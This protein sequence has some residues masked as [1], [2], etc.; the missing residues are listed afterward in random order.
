MSVTNY[1]YG[2]NS[3][4]VNIVNELNSTNIM[5]GVDTA[6][7]TLGWTKIREL[8]NAVPGSFTSTSTFSPMKTYVYKALNADTTTYKYL[9]IDWD[10][11][12]LMFFTSTCES[13]DE[14]S[15]IATNQSWAGAGA[16]AQRYDLKDCFIFVGASTRHIVLWS[17]PK[18][19]P[20]IWTGVFEFERTVPEDTVANAAPCWA[21]T[22]S[23]MIGTPHARASVVS[24][25]MFAFPRTQDNLTGAAAAAVYAPVTNRGMYPPSY[26]SGTLAITVDAN[27]LHLGSFYNMTYGWDTSSSKVYASPVS[28]DAIAKYMPFGRIYN[29]SVTGQIG[30]HLDT[31]TV[32]LDT[33]GGW[34]S[35]TGTNTDCTILPMNGGAEIGT[36]TYGANKMATPIAS[37][38]LTSNSSKVLVI[39]DNVWSCNQQG[40]YYWP[41][42]S[43][44]V[45]PTLAWSNPS[46]TAAN[47]VIDIVFDGQRTIYGSTYY[48]LVKIDTETLVATNLTFPNTAGSGL[49]VT[50]TA[51]AGTITAATIGT[52]GSGYLAGLT[53]TLYFSLPTSGNY[54]LLSIAVTAGVPSG[55]ITVVYGG[56]GYTSAGTATA[57][58]GMMGG[59]YINIDNK[60]VY[61][62]SRFMML[63]PTVTM[64]ARSTFTAN[65]AIHT[66]NVA[67]AFVSCWG[68][69]MPDYNGLCFVASQHGSASSAQSQ[70]Q[71]SFT[72]DT[73]VVVS[74]TY[75]LQNIATNTSPV[76]ATSYYFD[77]STGDKYCFISGLTTGVMHKISSSIV[78]LANN[79]FNTSATVANCYSHRVE[80]STDYLGDLQITAFRGIIFVTTKGR[81]ATTYSSRVALSDPMHATP[82]NP[83][84]LLQATATI[85]TNVMGSFTT[86]LHITGPRV[87]Y[88]TSTT[89][90]Y[91]SGAFTTSS[92]Q[93]GGTSRLMLKV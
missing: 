62:T 74:D 44:T 25:I 54:A 22:S 36:I 23:V 66:C 18:S 43:G 59:G 13:F 91:S 64:V 88:A 5:S 45:V 60:Y 61:V 58:I 51:P 87:V 38:A 8:D 68:V 93:A 46:A 42:S 86:G 37:S 49:T 24:K 35:S 63:K 30:S 76:N 26:P 75:N 85:G 55:A 27:L 70:R 10:Y 81:S 57:T 9:I 4:R 84:Y 47:Q 53:G 80:A 19:E 73:G 69:P 32:P 77:Y 15:F 89:L 6:I 11:L 71:S 79:T 14:G 67:T 2:A 33:T 34:I 48:G 92:V 41:M 28:V 65:A 83:T 90:A 1:L 56:T 82:G 7:T 50:T 52:A 39:G 72:A 21:W 78:S 29:L 16:F 40:I 12:R 17:F 20:D 3:Y 31:L